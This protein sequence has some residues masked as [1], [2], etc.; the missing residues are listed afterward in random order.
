MR[1]SPCRPEARALTLPGAQ[2]NSVLISCHFDRRRRTLPPQWRNP[3]FQPP[4]PP[5]LSV[6]S[7]EGGALCRRSGE[8]RFSTLP[9][10]LSCHF[11][12]R[13]RS[14][15]PQ[16]R[17]PLLQA[18][19]LHPNESGCD[20][21]HRQ[22]PS[23]RQILPRGILSFDQKNLL[24]PSPAL[25]LFLTRD[26]SRSCG[27]PFEPH[28]PLTPV[29]VRESLVT[30]LTVL[31]DP[32]LEITSHSHV[33]H[34]AAIRNE[35]HIKPSLSVHPISLLL[36]LLFPLFS[37]N[38]RRRTLPPQWRNP[39]LQPQPRPNSTSFR[40]KAAH[41]AA[42]V[43]KPASP[44][45]PSNRLWKPNTSP[46]NLVKPLNPLTLSLQIK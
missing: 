45:I 24:F 15:P 43:E 28:Q 25:N 2:A 29:S 23:D 20:A 42:A 17:N 32:H 27:K 12:R 34:A 7:T 19:T 1:L 9:P 18:Q 3:L 22:V 8:T 6:I 13:R 30:P 14:L 21:S 31:F 16:W 33:Q 4:S 10:K 44:P 5:Q 46:E 39:L 35:I 36:P 26:C 38:R 40:P 37:S 41:F 11:D